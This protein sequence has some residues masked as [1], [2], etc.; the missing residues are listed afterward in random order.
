MQPGLDAPDSSLLT[1]QTVAVTIGSIFTSF[2]NSTSGLQ[3]IWPQ[4]RGPDRTNIFTGSKSLSADWKTNPPKVLWK[5]ET[6]EGHAAPVIYKGLAYFLDYN[7]TTKTEL[8]RCFLLETGVEQW[9]RGH[10]IH[11]KRN[12]GMSRTIP[13][14]TENY[15]VT[16]GPVG[17]VMCCN[18]TDGSLVWSLNLQEKYQSEIPFW[19]T[20]QCPLVVND[21]A[22]IAAAGSML[23]LG[24]DCKTGTI[25]WETPNDKGIKMSHSSVMLYTILGKSMYVYAGVGGM[26]GVSAQGPDK[27]KMLWFF[28]TWAPTVVAPSPLQVS[29]NLLYITAGYGAGGAVV[30]IQ[31]SGNTYTAIAKDVFLPDQ[32]ASSE[33]QTYILKNNIIY[34]VLPKDAGA[35]RNQ[36]AGYRVPDFRNPVLLSGKTHR[37]GL[38]PFMFFNDKVLLLTDE[39]ILIQASIKNQQF[40]IEQSVELFKGVDAW[41]PMAY[42]DGYLLVRDSK[43]IYCVSLP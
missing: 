19:Y 35:N 42:A 16:L 4:F 20:G 28:N 15:I 21:T 14:V 34:G 25:A 11:I 41:G 26:A 8:L 37:F 2:D 6:G 32:G 40:T 22:I 31:K 1:N 3:E 10:K 39:G 9:Q 23:M 24:I 17:L 7:E 12:H 33:Q 18:R 27:G 36:F 5:T 30:E 38:G 13:S 43:N 29:D